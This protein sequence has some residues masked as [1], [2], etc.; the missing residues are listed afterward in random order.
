[1]TQEKKCFVSPEDISAVRLRC[2]KCKAASI[3]PIDKLAGDG[4]IA[5]EITRT[6][7]HCRTASGFAAGTREFEQFAEF[8]ML[9]G[10]LTAILEGRNIEFSLQVEWPE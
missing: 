2:V 5:V 4:N 3:V 6:C 1:M 8:N 10:N 9:L 7:P